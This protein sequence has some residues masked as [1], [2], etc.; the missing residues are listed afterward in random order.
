MPPNNS[1]MYKEEMKT[2]VFSLTI[3]R[4]KSDV[5]N[6]E[7]QRKNSDVYRSS[8]FAPCIFVSRSKL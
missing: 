6:N 2:S 3:Y 1:Q 7:N 8:R 5:S 4:L